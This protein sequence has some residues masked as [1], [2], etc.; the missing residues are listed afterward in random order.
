MNIGKV[1]KTRRK[2][3]GLTQQEL[4]KLLGGIYNTTISQWEGGHKTPNIKCWPALC[5]A[6]Q[7]TESDLVAR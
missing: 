6:L 3:L 2:A 7:C 1:I 5:K 4:G